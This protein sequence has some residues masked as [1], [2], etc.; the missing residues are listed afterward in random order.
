MQGSKIQW[1]GLLLLAVLMGLSANASFGV[2]Q[3][4][5]ASH[6]TDKFAAQATPTAAPKEEKHGIS[7]KAVEI[8]CVFGLPITNSMVV[9]WIVALGL[10]AFARL[11]TRKMNQVPGGAQK[12]FGVG[13]LARRPTGTEKNKTGNYLSPLPIPLF[14]FP[15]SVSLRPW[16]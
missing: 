1:F 5:E 6:I 10:I 14:Q 4:P 8:G 12:V 2:A 3:N 13:N 9:S 15:F 16:C 11:A 7:Q